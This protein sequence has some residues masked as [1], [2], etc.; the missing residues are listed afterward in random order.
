M[1]NADASGAVLREAEQR[2]NEW[3]RIL[4]PLTPRGLLPR[5]ETPSRI[6][7]DCA[8]DSTATSRL[9]EPIV[10]RPGFADAEFL[11][12]MVDFASSARAEAQV[13]YGRTIS[14]CP[15][16]VVGR[17]DA[18]RVRE[19]VEEL[20][21]RSIHAKY[22][23]SFLYYEEGDFIPLHVDNANRFPLNLLLC[24]KRVRPEHAKR[25]S[26]TYF[27]QSSSV[28]TGYDLA[29][30]QAAWFHAAE[31]PHGRTPLGPGEEAVLLTLGL[32]ETSWVSG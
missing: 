5:P 25:F 6:L 16:E 2:T 18:A 19:S 14:A 9:F 1:Q 32:Q 26:A 31:T 27:V 30:G 28:V 13:R 17:L 7:I 4:M 23:C 11:A 20:Y 24:L 8:A 3:S 10:L 29:P 22:L 12:E 15:P 21:G